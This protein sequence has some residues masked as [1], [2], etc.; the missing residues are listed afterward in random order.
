VYFSNAKNTFAP[1]LPSNWIP[2]T[3]VAMILVFINMVTINP[4]ARELTIKKYSSFKSHSL[5]ILSSIYFGILLALCTLPFGTFDPASTTFIMWIIAVPEYWV[6]KSL[7]SLD[8][9][10]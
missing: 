4:F 3:M 10:I 5:L 1:D 9:E 2:Y 8:V 6:W 7:R